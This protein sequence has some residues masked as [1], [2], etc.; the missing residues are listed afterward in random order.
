MIRAAAIFAL[1]AAP[2]W[3]APSENSHSSL[4][5]AIVAAD[6]PHVAVVSVTNHF[7]YSSNPAPFD[8]GVGTLIVRV[9]VDEGSGSLPDTVSIEAPEGFIAVPMSVDLA[10]DQSGE[11]L[12]FLI[13]GV[14][15]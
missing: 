2:A 11:I 5:I 4:D 10:E 6:G 9:T 12:I 8:I 3:A 1:L 14:G 7:R 13:E 15:M